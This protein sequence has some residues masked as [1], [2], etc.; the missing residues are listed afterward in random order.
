MKRYQS[1]SDRTLSF[2]VLHSICWCPTGTPEVEVSAATHAVDDVSGMAC[3][4]TNRKQ[5]AMRGNRLWAK[6]IHLK[7]LSIDSLFPDTALCH[8]DPIL[9]FNPSGRQPLLRKVSHGLCVISLVK[10]YLNIHSGCQ[11]GETVACFVSDRAKVTKGLPDAVAIME[12]KVWQCHSYSETQSDIDT[13]NQNVVVLLL[14]V[15]DEFI[16][17]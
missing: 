3:C 4:D 11:S 6:I 2:F 10:K 15:I 13:Q 9:C 14:L 7:Q 12:G 16:F 8:I 5:W 1:K 17:F